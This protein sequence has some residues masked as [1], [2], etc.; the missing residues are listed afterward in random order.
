[1]RQSR[2]LC[3]REFKF[4]K[5]GLTG[6]TEF[7]GWHAKLSS[8]PNNPV[9]PVPIS[10][11]W[12]GA[13]VPERALHFDGDKPNSVSPDF[14]SAMI[15]YLVRLAPGA[16]RTASG[17][18]RPPLE[19]GVMRRYPRMSGPAVLPLFCLAPHGVFPAS[20]LARRAVS[21]YLAF[22][23]LPDESFHVR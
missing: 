3:V 21:S 14:S 22:S 12:K 23:P 18:H 17:G 7:A 11:K 2:N 9:N 4:L 13:L 16:H 20:A 10:R 15:I 8:N 6:L 19:S 5:T 1:M